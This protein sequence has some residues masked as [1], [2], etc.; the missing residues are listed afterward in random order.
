MLA[1]SRSF[2]HLHGLTTPPD[3]TLPEAKKLLADL[4]AAFSSELPRHFEVEEK[5]LFPLLA[6]SG[7]EQLV[8]ILLEDHRLIRDLITI[9]KPLISKALKESKLS[10]LEWQ[11]FFQQADALITE[12]SA[13]AEKEDAGLVPELEEILDEKQ[14]EEIYKRYRSLC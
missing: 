10:E 11:T 4:N 8:D 12:L 1:R 13:H 5:D 9:L 3:W 7:L 6:D 2:L 14:A